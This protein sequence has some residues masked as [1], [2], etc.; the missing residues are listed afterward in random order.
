M[1]AI[2]TIKQIYNNGQLLPIYETAYTLQGEGYHA[3]KPTFLIRIAGC[4]IGCPWCDTKSAWKPYPHQLTSV[5]DLA[6]K[7]AAF[8]AKS[9]LVTGG[10]PLNYNLEP[11]TSEM[12][13]RNVKTYLETTGTQPLSGDWD[14]ICVSPKPFKKSLPQVVKA[15]NELKIIIYSDSDFLL[16]QEYANLIDTEKTLLFLQPEWSRKQ[17]MLPKIID[18]IKQN[19][20][21]RLSLQI[22][23]YLGIV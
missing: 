1:K 17:T 7:A 20:Q 8:P 5:I 16:A 14:W 3:G 18:F 6:E 23:K 4:D 13:H 19:P 21:W 12:K 2:S 10:E 9:L 11:L 22:H 15:A